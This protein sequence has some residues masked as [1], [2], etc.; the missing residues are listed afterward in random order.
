MFIQVYV[1]SSAKQSSETERQGLPALVSTTL[2]L[3]MS[4]HHL[5]AVSVNCGACSDHVYVER[6]L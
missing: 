2:V 5:D 3:H 6:K 4:T 1:P